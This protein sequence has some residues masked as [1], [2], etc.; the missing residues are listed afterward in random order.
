M[1]ILT[2]ILSLGAFIYNLQLSTQDEDGEKYMQYLY[3][4]S[5]FVL[6]IYTANIYV[7]LFMLGLLYRFMRP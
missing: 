7:D 1:F 4:E 5:L 6:M 3:I 2:T